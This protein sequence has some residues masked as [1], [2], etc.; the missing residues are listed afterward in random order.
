M[1]TSQGNQALGMSS[2]G[3]R[4]L[5]FDLWTDFARQELAAFDVHMVLFW[6]IAD[7]LLVPGVDAT[8]RDIDCSD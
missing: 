8:W 4:Q 5:F 2:N 3:T 1:A 6:A 7:G